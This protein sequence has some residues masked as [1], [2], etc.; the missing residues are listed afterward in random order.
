MKNVCNITHHFSG[1]VTI[2]LLVCLAIVLMVVLVLSPAYADPNFTWDRAVFWDGRYPS[3]WG[4]GGE[5]VRDALEAAG[6]TILDA[7]QLKTWMEGHIADK[8]LSVVVFSRDVVPDTVA[9]TMTSDC[10]IRTYLDAGGKVVWYSDWPFYYQGS[11]DGSWV[12]WGSAGAASVLGFNA[13][14][15]PNDTYEV[16][17]IT[18]AG[19]LWGLTETWESRRPTSPTI[20]ENMTAL[21][22]ISSG[23]AAAWVKHYLPGDQYR[24]FVRTFDREGAPNV[25]DDLIR[26]AEYPNVPEPIVYYVDDDATG[27]NDGSSWADAYWFL[28]DALAAAQ[29]GDEIRVA[30]GT[31]V[32]DQRVM[33]TARGT[34]V[35]SSGDRTETF[36]LINGVS[37]KG[38]YA[39]FGE[40]D[41][42]VRDIEAYVTILS[43]DLN[44]DDTA[45]ANPSDLLD[46]PTRAEN[47][48]HVVTGSRGDDTSVLDGFTI[49]AGNADVHPQRYG[50]GM[51]NNHCFNLTIRNCVFLANSAQNGG[52]MVNNPASPTLINCLF[53]ENLGSSAGAGIYN[54]LSSS[55]RL[56]GCKFIR[57][58]ANFAGGG[59]YSIAGTA[60][61]L[62]N[63]VF[64]RN[65]ASLH[66]G[67]LANFNGS[68]Q[69]LTNCTFSSNSA[70][71][72]GATASLKSSSSTLTNCILWGNT[73][74]SGFQVALLDNSSVAVNYCDVQGGLPGIDV[75]PTSLVTWG[76][77]NTNA[78]PLFVDAANGDYHLQA[79]SPCIDAGDNSAIPAGVIVDLGGDPRIKNGIVDMGAYEVG[80]APP[81]PER[82]VEGA[83]LSV[84]EGGILLQDGK[85]FRAIGVNYSDAFERV[86]L[87]PMDTSYRQGFSELAA[88]RIPFARFMTCYWPSQLAM[89]EN[90]REDFFRRLDGVIQAAEDYGI[91]L[92]PSLFWA[93]FAVP[94]LVGEPI[95]QWGN[96]NSKTIALMRRYT[97]DIVSR[98]KDSPAI[99]A[100]E[101]GNEYSLQADLPNAADWRPP[102]VPELGT[103]LTRGPEDDLTTDRI[104]T[105]FKEFATVVRSID[106]TRPITTGN[107]IPRNFA[108]DIRSGNRWSELDTRADF[109]ANISLVTPFP[110]DMVS[111]HLYPGEVLAERFEPGYHASYSELI[112]LAMEVSVQE[113]KALFV[114]EFGANDITQGG[115]E[116]AA[117]II[118]EIL[119]ALVEN[120][121]P[122]AAIWVYDRVVTDDEATQG[123]NII[124]S[125]SR[126]YILE[127]IRE[128]N[129][130]ISVDSN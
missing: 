121:V 93:Y 65:S 111:I 83:G 117:R 75:D 28:Q 18:D 119:D 89:Y 58:R 63:C 4:G 56:F 5:G 129:E 76:L 8:E 59:M 11:S 99:W 38:G 54:T 128:A 95:N 107:S 114:G 2:P 21:A 81:P 36:Q 80:M 16:V 6:Y 49:T 122:L 17:A 51:R 87:D 44:G 126:S 62:T 25:I 77:G 57:N 55:P 52:A 31:Y 101:F 127:A 23:S 13:S 82:R 67:G 100:W 124:A 64:S 1:R 104:V 3:V 47:S 109:K 97:R 69:T 74:S 71:T 20:S 34:Q 105:A 94:D 84:G 48:F 88:H 45:V 102:I 116:E 50:G 78:D 43:G 66:G 73:T 12:T 41:P 7:D 118:Q 35:R 79:S 9:E 27:A 91:G 53:I 24:G 112:S 46:D 110:H 125:N 123:W 22:T 30:Q 108:A 60:P 113:G 68:E 85:P 14:S 26:L 72:G 32:P 15:G 33:I 86:L 90:D 42:D 120:G 115:A 92:I 61:H 130:A 40:P 106:P 39:G 19:T 96:P 29:G 98:Y 37:L 10:T 103:P 70:G